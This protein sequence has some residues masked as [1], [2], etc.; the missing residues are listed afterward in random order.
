MISR[1]E[2]SSEENIQLIHGNIDGNGLSQH[3]N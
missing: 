2:L 1:H 3:K